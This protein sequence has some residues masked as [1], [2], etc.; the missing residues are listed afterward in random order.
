MSLLCFNKSGVDVVLAGSLG[1]STTIPA[2]L[3]P[4]A[5]GQ[6]VNVTSEL[7]GLTG[8][9]YTALETQRAAAA[10]EYAWTGD[11]EFS[12]GTLTVMGSTPGK[13]APT[14]GGGSDPLTV[15]SVA[16]T[17]S[18][19]TA[20]VGNSNATLPS[21]ETFPKVAATIPA[22]HAQFLADFD[23]TTALTQPD[24]A[25]NLSVAFGAGWPGTV[26]VYVEGIGADGHTLKSIILANPG[27][28][29]DGVDAYLLVSRTF[30]TTGI[31]PDTC[32]PSVGQVTPGLTATAD[33]SSAS[34]ATTVLGVSKKGSSV[35]CFK[36][37]ADG[38]DDAFAATTPAKG[39]FRP[40]TPPDG[41][42]SFTVWYTYIHSHTATDSGHSHA[43]PVHTHGLTG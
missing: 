43:S 25:R 18:Q 1:F 13:H 35:A 3:A 10:L 24:V 7:R 19:G 36:L 29:V 42:K 2:S 6:A 11:P 34:A 37:N 30:S 31:D 4:P 15:G 12:V 9:Q 22:I 26:N 8:G 33:L 5:R 20:N 39:T 27:A 21:V 40:T 41:A 32:I 38:V 28:S 17:V 16:A 14:H 23:A